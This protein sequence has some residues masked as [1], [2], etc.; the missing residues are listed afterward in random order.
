MTVHSQN[1]DFEGRYGSMWLSLKS[2]VFEDDA[3]KMVGLSLKRAVF[4]DE[5]S[6]KSL[7]SG[8][9][10]MIFLPSVSSLLKIW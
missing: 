7:S 5:S 4:E 6:E 1:D 10:L 3:C 8:H 9:L 2:A